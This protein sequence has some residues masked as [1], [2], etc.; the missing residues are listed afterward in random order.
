LEESYF[1]RGILGARL[2]SHGARLKTEA[3]ATKEKA[4]DSAVGASP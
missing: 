4:G 2:E 3:A 1:A